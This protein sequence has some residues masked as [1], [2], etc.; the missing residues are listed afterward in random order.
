[1]HNAV[2]HVDDVCA[3]L[4]LNVDD[5]CGISVHP[6]GL[7]HVL[8]AVDYVS[9]VLH[10]HR[11]AIPISDDD[12]LVIRSGINLVIS[13][14]AERLLRA[15][16]VALGLVGIR[17]SQSTAKILEAESVRRQSR[18]VCL[19]AYRRF[20]SPADGHQAHSGKLRDL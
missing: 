14:N 4:A 2:H 18:W 13:A 7:L 16:D 5:Y 6:G 9:N 19:D 3:R 1:L 10:S 12:W 8:D 15:L 11:R 17:G 20:L